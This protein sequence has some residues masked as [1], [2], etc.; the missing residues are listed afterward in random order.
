MIRYF[1][2][3]AMP[4]IPIP[5]NVYVEKCTCGA[6]FCLG[7]TLNYHPLQRSPFANQAGCCYAV[8]QVRKKAVKQAGPSA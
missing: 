6:D 2:I 5:P 7:W 4:G 3:N 8:G 1:D